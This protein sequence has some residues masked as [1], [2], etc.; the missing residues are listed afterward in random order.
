MGSG[1]SGRIMGV[2]SEI[3]GIC[4]LLVCPS[5]DYRGP[6]EEIEGEGLGIQCAVGAVELCELGKLWV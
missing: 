6:R 3:G 4:K 2:L 5:R 1:G